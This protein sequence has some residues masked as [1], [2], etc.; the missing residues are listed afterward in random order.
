LGL[1]GLARA[2][3][4]PTRRARTISWVV[5]PRVSPRRLLAFGAPRVEARAWRNANREG[6]SVVTETYLKDELA[7][8]LASYLDG[9]PEARALAERLARG[10]RERVAVRGLIGSARGFLAGWL[11]R[12]TGKTVLYVVGHGDAF[13]QA[14]DD[15]EYFRGRGDTLVFPEPDNLPYDPASPH[16]AI[17]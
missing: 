14:R 1:A 11:Q 4:Q 8:S 5:P 10:V 3:E 2:A 15:L 12:V 9:V 6:M 13:E 16:P 17:T 7:E